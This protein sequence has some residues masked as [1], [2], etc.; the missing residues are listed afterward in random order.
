[1]L[2]GVP[3]FLMGR[4][5]LAVYTTG[6]LDESDTDIDVAVRLEDETEIR[7]RLSEWRVR[8]EVAD[9][10]RV[11]QLFYQPDGV[12]VDLHFFGTDLPEV[13]GYKNQ[14]NKWV[15]RPAV[16]FL[17][18]KRHI[19]EYGDVGTPQHPETWLHDDY[20]PGWREKY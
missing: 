11:H 14:F 1:M 4:S 10:P 12:L 7:E 2:E 18:G 3:W 17:S 16:R 20:G 19:E 15:A 8:Q 13:R 9:G 6:R 5:L